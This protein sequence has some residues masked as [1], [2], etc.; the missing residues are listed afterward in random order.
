MDLE[1]LVE[2]IRHL[3]PAEGGWSG[4]GGGGKFGGR[5]NIC[6]VVQLFE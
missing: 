5:E 6:E 3:E 2:V 4:R 1:F